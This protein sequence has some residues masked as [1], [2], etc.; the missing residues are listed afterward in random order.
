MRV[1]SCR[2]RC[3]VFVRLSTFPGVFTDSTVTCFHDD[4]P[5]IRLPTVRSCNAGRIFVYVVLGSDGFTANAGTGVV[6]VA[7][8]ANL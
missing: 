2:Q 5:R 4:S 6:V 7:K 8:V 3:L 1:G